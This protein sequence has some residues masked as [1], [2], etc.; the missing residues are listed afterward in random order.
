MTTY[1]PFQTERVCRRQN[2]IDENGEAFFKR[3]ENMVGRGEIYRYKLSFFSHG[4]FKRIV[5]QT[6]KNRSCLGKGSRI[7]RLKGFKTGMD[8]SYYLEGH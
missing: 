2:Q 1:R 4:V 7:E 6:R 8:P 3:I 5:L